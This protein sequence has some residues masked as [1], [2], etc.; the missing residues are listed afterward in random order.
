MQGELHPST[1]RL[2]YS[3][4]NDK[5]KNHQNNLKVWIPCRSTEW[6]K[7]KDRSVGTIPMKTGIQSA[8]TSFTRLSLNPVESRGNLKLVNSKPVTI[9]SIVLYRNISF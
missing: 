4:R 7:E 6:R 9:F 8:C 1:S 3:V 2:G 5:S